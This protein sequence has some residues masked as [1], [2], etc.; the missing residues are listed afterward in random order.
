MKR[1]DIAIIG[2]GPG[3]YTAAIRAAQLGAT[4]CLLEKERVGGTCLNWGCIPTKALL[5][6]TEL[7]S[8]IRRAGEYGLKV[9]GVDANWPLMIERKDKVVEKLVS[10]VEF[11]LKSYKVDLIQARGR[12]VDREIIGIEET[13]GGDDHISAA[14]IIL[15]TGSRPA[16]MPAFDIP[17]MRP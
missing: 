17:A 13:N 10:G 14:N 12:L 8:R 7:L 2:G 16:Y 15:A 6:C 9:E 4:V 11:L 3:G 5:S 1:Y